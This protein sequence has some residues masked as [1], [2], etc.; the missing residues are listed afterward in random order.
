M[1][2]TLR[3]SVYSAWRLAVAQPRRRPGSLRASLN[4][5]PWVEPHD[6]ETPSRTH[7]VFPAAQ[8]VR[9]YAVCLI[10]FYFNGTML[11]RSQSPMLECPTSLVPFLRSSLYL[12]QAPEELPYYR[13]SY[14]RN[15]RNQPGML[16][17]RMSPLQYDLTSYLL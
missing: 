17:V 10:I 3:L 9:V 2:P 7:F 12:T 6:A 15:V 16:H 11:P 1:H 13:Y 14:L 4:Y 5:A 8:R